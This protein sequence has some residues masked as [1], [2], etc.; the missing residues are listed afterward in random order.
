M[1]PRDPERVVFDCNIYA[2][3]LISPKGPAAACLTA[4]QQGKISLFVSDYVLQEVREL[5]EK[6]KPKYGVDD[7]KIEQL[8]QDLET[9]AHFVKDVPSVYIHPIDPD[10][11]HYID[12]AYAT[13]S[14]IV[15]TRDRHLHGLMDVSQQIGRDF[16]KLFPTIVV[17]QPEALTERIRKQKQR[18]E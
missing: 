9:F 3:A 4:A 8:V 7:K 18:S 12:L 15:A 17:M 14:E 1:M 13:K 16:K 10:D 5:P 2:Q 11:S 6:L